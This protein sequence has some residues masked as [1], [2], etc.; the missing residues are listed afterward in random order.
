MLANVILFLLLIIL[1]SFPGKMFELLFL[2][3][4]IVSV[5]EE[6]LWCP[7]PTS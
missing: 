3:K 1:L 6:A 4:F 5:R 2:L 7:F